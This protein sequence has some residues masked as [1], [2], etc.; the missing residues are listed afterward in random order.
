MT[1]TRIEETNINREALF[2]ES[3]LGEMRRRWEGVQAGFVDDPRAAVKQADELVDFATKRLTAMFSDE[4]S[5]MEADWDKGDSVSTE[6]LRLAFRRYRA[7]FDRILS[8]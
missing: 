3:D 4:R 6:D 1:P 5:R 7:F 2:P 8:V